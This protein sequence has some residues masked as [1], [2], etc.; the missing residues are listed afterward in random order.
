M[1]RGRVNT[2]KKK[3]V[4]A[5]Y[6]EK[7][8]PKVIQRAKTNVPAINIPSSPELPVEKPPKSP[9]KSPEKEMRKI[10]EKVGKEIKRAVS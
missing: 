8:E 2:V 6:L 4:N 9:K 5:I 1:P 10:V 7:N 3:V